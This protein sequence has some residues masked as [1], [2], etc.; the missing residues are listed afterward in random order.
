MKTIQ[1]TNAQNKEIQYS[2]NNDVAIITLQN[3]YT[4]VDKK[5]LNDIIELSWHKHE[6][7]YINHSIHNY[8]NQFVNEK[9]QNIYLHQFV[10]KYCGK[11]PNPENKP[12]IDHINRNKFDNR[13]CNLRWATIT[14]QNQNKFTRSDKKLPCEELISHGIS[15][16]PRFVRYDK[17]QERFVLEK[18]PA[19]V[20]Q[21]EEGLLKKPQ[22]NGTR[23]G[24]IFQRLYD[25]VN[26]GLSF[27]SES[28]VCYQYTELEQI[29]EEFNRSRDCSL[30]MIIE[31]SNTLY[32][33]YK[34]ILKKLEKIME[35]KDE[36]KVLKKGL[37]EDCGIN[38]DMIPKYCYYKPESE[39]RGCCF[40]IDR[41]PNMEKRLWS[42]TCS[43]KVSIQE[44]YNCL[45]NKLNDL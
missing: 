24:S 21:V 7:G 13:L 35:N 23:K 22:K 2:Y 4:I 17:S 27:E 37:P 28:E 26:L 33:E 11:V 9:T 20:K 1:V 10:M 12:Q 39:S 42:T 6:T 29:C 16:L 3:G 31:K 44:K 18:H 36:K 45:L 40:V 43:K 8:S 25:I 14:E 34:S 5:Y 15:E 38:P 30:E 19:L 41:H 32:Y